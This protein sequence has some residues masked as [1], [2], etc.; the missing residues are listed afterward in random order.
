MPEMDSQKR[1][2]YQAAVMAFSMV[3]TSALGCSDSGTGQQTGPLQLSFDI[4]W[5]SM[6]QA[7][8]CT[9]MNSQWRTA[10]VLLN[11]QT[12]AT[13][14]QR[15]TAT[16]PLQKSVSSRVFWREMHCVRSHPPTLGKVHQAALETSLAD[17]IFM[18]PSSSP[19]CICK[20]LCL[21][22]YFIIFHSHACVWL[23][24]LIHLRVDLSIHFVHWV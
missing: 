7:Q 8:I 16:I 1:A 21:Y 17:S 12:F 15:K 13:M 4:H 19:S 11:Y 22:K 23:I 6:L 14:Q 20:N 3:A 9:S 24:S 2:C 5:H 10:Q 18:Y